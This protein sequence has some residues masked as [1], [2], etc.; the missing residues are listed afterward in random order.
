MLGA[1]KKYQETPVPPPA[2][3]AGIAT[4]APKF[5]AVKLDKWRSLLIF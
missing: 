4:P 5:H 3:D 1:V 2:S